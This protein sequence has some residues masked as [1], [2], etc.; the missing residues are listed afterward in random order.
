MTPFDPDASKLA[1][2]PLYEKGMSAV[3]LP[4]MLGSKQVNFVA[5]DFMLHL[6][7]VTL[8]IAFVA[9]FAAHLFYA[10]Q[11]AAATT[12][13]PKNGS[14]SHLFSRSVDMLLVTGCFMLFYINS[15]DYSNEIAQQ[16]YVL[17]MVEALTPPA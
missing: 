10:V 2:G 3:R 14:S 15:L 1:D 7:A 13:H 12:L 11:Q 6:F 4:E 8:F 5:S 16:S 17:A 9:P